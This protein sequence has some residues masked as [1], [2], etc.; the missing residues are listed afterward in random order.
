MDDVRIYDRALSGAEIQGLAAPVP[1]PGA[2][3]LGMIGIGM[4]GAYTRRRRL[5]NVTE[6]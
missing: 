2:M 6:D 4:V 5:A 1:V 3:V